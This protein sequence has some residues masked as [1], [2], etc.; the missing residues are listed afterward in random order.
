MS[1]AQVQVLPS[2]PHSVMVDGFKRPADA[3][4]EW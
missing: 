1:K 2:A 4:N 3:G